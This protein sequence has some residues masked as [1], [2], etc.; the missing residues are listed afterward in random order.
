MACSYTYR[1]KKNTVPKK[2]SMCKGDVRPLYQKSRF[3]I[4]SKKVELS[5]YTLKKSL[6]ML[7]TE[8]IPAVRFI[9]SKT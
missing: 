8:Y 7:I 4:T 6:R 2:L 1:E 9:I 5:L 3:F